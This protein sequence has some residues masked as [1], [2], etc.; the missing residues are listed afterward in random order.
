MYKRQLL[1]RT[2]IRVLYEWYINDGIRTCERL[3]VAIKGCR[4]VALVGTYQP[5]H[6]YSVIHQLLFWARCKFSCGI[7]SGLLLHRLI[8]ENMDLFSNCFVRKSRQIFLTANFLRA[9]A[10]SV[11]GRQEYWPDR[12]WSRWSNSSLAVVTGC[13]GSVQCRF[14]IGKHVLDQPGCTTPTRKHELSIDHTGREMG[15]DHADHLSEVYI[16]TVRL[17]GIST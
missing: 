7:G 13:A 3:F 14:K 4:P 5:L 8:S 16:F 12:S 17:R 6:E 9:V 2:I 15:I 1:F 11:R 10:C